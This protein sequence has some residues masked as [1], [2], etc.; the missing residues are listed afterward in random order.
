M[1]RYEI[2]I[3]ATAG[4]FEWLTAAARSVQSLAP[5]MASMTAAVTSVV[6]AL[7]PRSGV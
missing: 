4:D 3:D 1:D 7:P 5:W 2:Q 6:R